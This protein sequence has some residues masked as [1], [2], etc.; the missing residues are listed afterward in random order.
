MI[1]KKITPNIL[2]LVFTKQSEMSRTMLRF[3]EHYES[4]KFRNKIFTLKEFKDWY[5]NRTESGK[6]TYYHD[7]GGFNVP[8]FIFKPFLIGQFKNLTA[9]E[10]KVLILL[11]DTNLD[12]TYIIATL[13]DNDALRHE[14]AHGLFYTK[15]SYKKS[16]LQIIK[17]GNLK[18]LKKHLLSHG[19]CK[20]VLNDECQAYLLDEAELLYKELKIPNGLKIQKKLQKLYNRYV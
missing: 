5:R 6:F 17:S 2:H 20:Q 13:K 16:A 18:K 3:Q 7:W 10:K 11:K 15:P 19:Y 9:R 14:I 1:L 8:G 12:K 4:P